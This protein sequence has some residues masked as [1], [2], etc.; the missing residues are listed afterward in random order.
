MERTN[1]YSKVEENNVSDLKLYE[2]PI[3]S[4]HNTFF[5]GNKFID[6]TYKEIIEL[7]KFFPVCIE[8]DFKP[9]D[10]KKT[11]KKKKLLVNTDNI[12]ERE[13]SED[14]DSDDDSD[15]DYD[16]YNSDD[17]NEKSTF[18][19]G[20]P[21]NNKVYI[22][23]CIQCG[24]GHGPLSKDFTKIKYF[25][26]FKY[27]NNIIDTY[28]KINN[29]FPLIITFDI[30]KTSFGK[31][32]KRS[33]I[34]S[35]SPSPISN[36][37]TK[38]K[39]ISWGLFRRS[40]SSSNSN[41]NSNSIPNTPNTPNNNVLSEIPRRLSSNSSSSSNTND[42]M[43]SNEN[44]RCLQNVS[45]YCEI[46]HKNFYQ[47]KEDM[48]KDYKEKSLA[49]CMGKIIVRLKKNQYQHISN[50][51]NIP[52]IMNEGSIG[53]DKTIKD[54][55]Y[56]KILRVF[57]KGFIFT[58]KISP[59][60]VNATIEMFEQKEQEQKFKNINMMAFNYRDIDTAVRDNL[61][62]KFR[63]FYKK[64]EENPISYVGGKA[65]SKTKKKKRNSSNKKKSVKKQK[66]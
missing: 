60:I 58:K 26:Q 15:S 63:K 8:I 5:E 62:D 21:V 57:P 30:E 39:R 47:N 32:R 25:D 9:V 16:D 31:K 14:D 34:A 38:K 12:V 50:N 65:K 42:I 28:K 17:K 37:K 56:N 18:V 11:I 10:L 7:C 66:K 13:K 27:L 43:K 61:I 6:T 29:P 40:K 53:Y 46:I 3:F 49:E 54:D 24:I 64:L 23:E 2:C 33:S 20:S 41:S 55:D 48:G 45:K 4:T 1:K 59:N 22:P 51:L 35:P 52:Y 19:G 36:V 44:T